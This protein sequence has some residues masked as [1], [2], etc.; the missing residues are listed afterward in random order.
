MASVI[1]L[2]EQSV[3]R[4]TTNEVLAGLSSMTVLTWL[5]AAST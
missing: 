1:T 3:G 5:M 4:L 2:A